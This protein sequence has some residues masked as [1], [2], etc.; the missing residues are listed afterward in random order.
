MTVYLYVQVHVHTCSCVCCTL[1]TVSVTCGNFEHQAIGTP[2]MQ[3]YW[4]LGFHLSRYG[5][6]TL[7]TMKAVVEQM[8]ECDMP[9]VSD[10]IS[11]R[12]CGPISTKL[13]AVFA[14][15]AAADTNTTQHTSS[16]ITNL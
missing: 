1:R 16:V 9:H 5:Y 15:V 8:R 7:D 2:V 3:T 13:A 11:V 6:N 14:A 10:V 12:V 4:A